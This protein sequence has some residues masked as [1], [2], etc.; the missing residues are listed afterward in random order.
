MSALL[1]IPAVTLNEKNAWIMAVVAVVTYGTY[2]TDVLGRA[3]DTPI[4]EVHY[5]STLLWTVGVSI[6]GSIVLNIVAAIVSPR[7]AGKADRRD[8][9]INRA[10]ERVGQSMLVLGG[11][12]ALVM[13]LAEVSYFW[14]AN[15]IYLAFVLSALIASATK[16]VAY[17]QGFRV[18]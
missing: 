15:V 14:I 4:A 5:V 2:L 11:V 9:E 18:W 8:R 7:D 12:A 6:A 13:A 3:A 17:R 1:Y 10:G 16:I